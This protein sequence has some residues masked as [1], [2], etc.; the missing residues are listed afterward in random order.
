[1]ARTERRFVALAG[2]LIAAACGGGVSPADAGTSSP[3]AGRAADAGVK[4]FSIS[5]VS[6]R[7]AQ[8]PTNGDSQVNGAIGVSR[9]GAFI[10]TATVTVNGVAIPLHPSIVGG[11]YDMSKAAI[12][13]ATPGAGSTLTIVATEGSDRAEVVV[14][15][16]TAVTFTSPADGSAL[17]VGDFTA[18]WTGKLDYNS[19]ATKSEVSLLQY[20]AA[21][22]TSNGFVNDTNTYR[23]LDGDPT[24][25]Q[26]HNPG[27]SL[28]GYLLQM[29][30]EG[31]A[32]NGP[33]GLGK[34]ATEFRIA[35]GK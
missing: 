17:A 13:N 15:C 20:D 22:Q 7:L 21:S 4:A 5:A 8:R 29:Y 25:A 35:L 11:F 23:F 2:A 6:V 24:S 12:P 31:V 14:T 18:T 34:C 9:D 30:T 3:D 33:D 10:S 32:V 26:L 19:G 16:P 27:G 28:P 1:M